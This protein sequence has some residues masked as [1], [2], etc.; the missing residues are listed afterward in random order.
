M[1]V[2]TINFVNDNKQQKLQKSIDNS[3]EMMGLFLSKFEKFEKDLPDVSGKVFVI[4]GKPSQAKPKSIQVNS[5]PS[6]EVHCHRIPI[7]GKHSC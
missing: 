4:T 5:A 3:K 1:L 7:L 6:V 2:V